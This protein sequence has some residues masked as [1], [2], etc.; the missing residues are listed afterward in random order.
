MVAGQ[1]NS[2]SDVSWATDAEEN[3]ICKAK[4]DA[5]YAALSLKLERR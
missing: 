4:H 3:K 2:G 1:S 5:L